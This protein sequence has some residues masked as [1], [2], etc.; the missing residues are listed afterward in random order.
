MSVPVIGS[1]GAGQAADIVATVVEDG[2][3]AVACASLFHYE[4]CP[5]Q[6]LK[7]HMAEAGIPIRPEASA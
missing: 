2:L 4:Q 7:A 1:G 6:M 5:P 3:D